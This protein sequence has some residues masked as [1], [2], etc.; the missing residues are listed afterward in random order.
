MVAAACASV[1][2]VLAFEPAPRN[3]MWLVRALELN[4]ISNV[5]FVP[6]DVSDAIQIA[7]FSPGKNCMT[8]SLVEN[9]KWNTV[10]PVSVAG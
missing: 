2:A 9:G 10:G 8:G 3:L 6:C 1:R 5:T 7:R 4:Y